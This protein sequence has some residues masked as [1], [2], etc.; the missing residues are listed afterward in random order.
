MT[1][2]YV[3]VEKNDWTKRQLRAGRPLNFTDIMVK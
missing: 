3:A 2:N 1:M